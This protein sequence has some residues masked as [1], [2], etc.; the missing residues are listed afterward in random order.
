MTTK[1][2]FKDQCDQCKKFDYLKSYNGKCLCS[3]CRPKEEIQLTL[4]GSEVLKNGQLRTN[5]T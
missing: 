3:Q 2:K 5:G 1:T 4:F